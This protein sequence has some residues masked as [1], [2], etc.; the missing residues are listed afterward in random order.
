MHLSD[1]PGQLNDALTGI[2]PPGWRRRVPD[3]A[4]NQSLQTD[5]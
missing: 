2:A 4:A 5:G 3:H 1:I